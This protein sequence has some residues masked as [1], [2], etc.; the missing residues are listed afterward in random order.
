MSLNGLKPWKSTMQI[1]VLQ[2]PEPRKIRN[3]K[4]DMYMII[5]NRN[6]GDY[7]WNSIEYRKD[8]DGEWIY[9]VDLNKMLL[10]IIVLKVKKPYKNCLQFKVNEHKIYNATFMLDTML[11][12]FDVEHKTNPSPEMKVSNFRLSLNL[13]VA[14]VRT[15]NLEKIV[16]SLSNRSNFRKNKNWL[17]RNAGVHYGEGT[18]FPSML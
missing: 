14:E 13:F 8:L 10:I 7:Y 12:F 17:L 6:L 11:C 1:L 2:R 16:E 18:K 15:D 5:V 9:T 4:K 3:A